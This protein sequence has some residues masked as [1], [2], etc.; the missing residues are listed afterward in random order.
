[1]LGGHQPGAGLVQVLPLGD[2]GLRRGEALPRRHSAGPVAELPIG[3]AAGY[4]EAPALLPAG[5]LHLP[6]GAHIELYGGDVAGAAVLQG[7]E[8]EVLAHRHGAHSAKALGAHAVAAPRGL[9]VQIVHVLP[10]QLALGTPEGLQA[11]DGV[12]LHVLQREGGQHLQGDSLPAVVGKLRP[13][14]QGV[15]LLALVDCQG[16]PL[17]ILIA[18]GGRV[19]PHLFKPLDGGAAR[20]GETAAKPR[21]VGIAHQLHLGTKFHENSPSQCG[22]RKAPILIR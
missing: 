13:H 6:G 17:A 8:G 4:G 14:P 18:E 3:Q 19:L 2:D 9:Q 11:V 10:A 20:K 15:L 22:A 5:N 7:Q 1:M 16:Q 21:A 12:R